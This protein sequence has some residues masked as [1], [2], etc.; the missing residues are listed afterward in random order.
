VAGSL[1]K[2]LKALFEGGNPDELDIRLVLPYY[3]SV[4]QQD[5][6]LKRQAAFSIPYITGQLQAEALRFDL[7]ELP[8]YFIKGDLF[9]QDGPIY[10]GDPSAD[11]KK[12]TFFSLA[13][14]ELA[15]TLKWPPHIVHANDWH[16]APAVYA[17]SRLRQVDPF[18]AHTSTVLGLHNL[19]FMGIGSGPALHDFGLPPGK[20]P[21]LPDWA[22][23]VPLPLGLSTAE[24]IVAVS[25]TYAREIMTPE[26]GSGLHQLLRKRKK[27]ISGILNGIDIEL[28][29][30][31]HDP[32]INFSF[33]VRNIETRVNN[34]LALQEEIGLKRDSNVPLI[35]LISRIDF[36][37]GIDLIPAALRLLARSKSSPSFQVVL[38]G[39]GDKVLQS[40][41]NEMEAD[42]PDHVKYVTRFDIDLSH[43]I[44]AGADVLLIPS[45][46]EPCGLT[47]MLA[48]RY[49]C[50]PVG[51]AT[52]GLKDTIKD[53]KS[54][55]VSTGFLFQRPTA[56]SLARALRRALQLY[57]KDQNAWRSLQV[58]G[59]RRDF[60]W[61]L[62]A[63]KYFRVY[64]N[65]VEA[66]HPNHVV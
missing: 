9:T 40:A 12:F 66:R 25:P 51:R 22:R 57:S 58:R 55:E 5:L 4:S 14:L 17:L 29:D 16:T 7:D 39:T 47:Q 65:L 13:A 28:W 1:P 24:H 30:P 53:Y 32:A 45:R 54:K 23:D 64:Q 62:S 41:L 34:K 49:G 21:L 50:I 2:S 37:K 3:G 20:D 19:P 36:Q 42:Y 15:R 27:N 60:S 26:Y 8:V 38:L 61:T 48:M 52:G 56:N 35:G 10:S 33:G 59:M 43:R 63:V 18:F 6:P 31:E 46:Y 44:Y 11:G